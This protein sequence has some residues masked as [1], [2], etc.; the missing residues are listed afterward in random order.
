ML[1]SELIPNHGRLDC[2]NLNT[3]AK[4]KRKTGFISYIALIADKSCTCI[5]LEKNNIRHREKLAQTELYRDVCLIAIL[6]LRVG[7][8]QCGIE[9]S[10]SNRSNEPGVFLSISKSCNATHAIVI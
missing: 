6:I 9:K 10:I 8:R 3:G 2:S 4:V 1:L 7:H 5:R